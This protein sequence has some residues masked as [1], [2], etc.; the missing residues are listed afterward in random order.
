MKKIYLLV[1]IGFIFS[2]CFFSSSLNFSQSDIQDKENIL[3]NGDFSENRDSSDFPKGWLLL[4]TEDEESLINNTSG[5]LEITSTNHKISLI[6]DSFPIDYRGAHLTIGKFRAKTEINKEIQLLLLTF[7]Q[8]GKKTNT[9]KVSKKIEKDWQNIMISSAYYKNV[10]K[11]ARVLIILPE[12][13]KGNSFLLEN[14]GCY[15][16]YKFK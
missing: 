2:S 8:H 6:S 10:A 15:E 5:H 3:F 11:F 13:S 7:D 1:I 4:N 14:F 12:S 16:I 9:F